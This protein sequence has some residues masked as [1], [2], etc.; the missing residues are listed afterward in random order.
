LR[1]CLAIVGVF[2]DRYRQSWLTLEG[3]LANSMFLGVAV[4]L[5]I[6]LST[7][8]VSEFSSHFELGMLRA[9]HYECPL[10]GRPASELG[11][12]YFP[13]MI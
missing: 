11:I 5:R 2:R 8:R 4:L 9:M 1:L 3:T 10:R 12:E 6:L 7:P 13:E